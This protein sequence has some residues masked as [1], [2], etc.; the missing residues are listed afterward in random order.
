MCEGGRKEKGG[1][2]QYVP[3]RNRAQQKATDLAGNVPRDSS[4]VRCHAFNAAGREHG[5]AS[6]Q[7]DTA[8]ESFQGQVPSIHYCVI[9]SCIFITFCASRHVSLAT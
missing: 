6:V 4:L 3:S 2:G 7:D 1:K 5:E 9:A 8:D